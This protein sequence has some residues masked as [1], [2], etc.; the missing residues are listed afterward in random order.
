M[1]WF[2]TKGICMDSDSSPVP[3]NREVFFRN[4]PIF[5]GGQDNGQIKNVLDGVLITV[6]KRCS[7]ENGFLQ[8][9]CGILIRL[10]LD[11]FAVSA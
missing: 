11:Q 5:E 6:R 3:G 2:A 8:V 7:I 10:G 1:L 4:E 9:L